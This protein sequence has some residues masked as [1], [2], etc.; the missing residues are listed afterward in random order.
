MKKNLIL[1][2]LRITLGFILA[3][4]CGGL[5]NHYVNVAIEALL[6]ATNIK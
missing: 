3:G 1:L 4:L 2:G 6:R 5:V